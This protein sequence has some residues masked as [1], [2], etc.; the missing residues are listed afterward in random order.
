MDP[1]RYS[2]HN[3]SLREILRLTSL[4][5]ISFTSVHNNSSKVANCFFGFTPS[6]HRIVPQ[7]PFRCH[8]EDVSDPEEGLGL[9]VQVSF[10][11]TVFTLP[12][13]QRGSLPRPSLK[14]HLE[15]GFALRCF[16]RLS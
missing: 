14:S 2:R 15:D 6:L 8:T 16:Q 1:H 11:I 10:D 7:I 12:A 4:P 3:I 9:L 13:Y 5:E